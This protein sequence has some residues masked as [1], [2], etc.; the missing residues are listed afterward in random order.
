MVRHQAKQA[1]DEKLAAE[2]REAKAK[3]AELVQQAA[4]AAA[5]AAA[6]TPPGA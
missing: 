3:L 5:P 1:K 2:L 6:E 4:V